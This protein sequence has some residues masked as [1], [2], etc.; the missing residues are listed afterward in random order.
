MARFGS[1]LGGW[2][3]IE[4][5]EKVN[6]PCYSCKN[7]EFPIKGQEKKTPDGYRVEMHSDVGSF[8]KNSIGGWCKALRVLVDGN[9]VKNESACA[10]C[11]FQTRKK[12]SEQPQVGLLIGRDGQTELFKI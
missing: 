5:W 9:L 10:G 4:E 6:S 11:Y 3:E 12:E 8:E 2:S 1:S 7:F